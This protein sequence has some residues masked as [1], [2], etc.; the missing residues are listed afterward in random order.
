MT[1]VAILMAI[2]FL[3]GAVAATLV[4]LPSYTAATFLNLSL[5]WLWL[6]RLEK[7]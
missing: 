4:S 6:A 2:T 5:I 7:R 1:H 3:F